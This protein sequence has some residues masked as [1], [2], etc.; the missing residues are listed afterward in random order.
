M[1]RYRDD[2][3][4]EAATNRVMML[5]AVLLFA[6]V[7]VFPLYRLIEPL[8][9]DDAR[10]GQLQ[11]LAQAGE[12]SWSV[13]CASCHGVS[14]DGAIGP[15]LNSMQ[16][17]QAASDDQIGSLIGVGVPGSQMNPYSQDHGGPLTSEQIKSL[18]VFI[19]S[20]EEDAP[21]RPDWRAMLGG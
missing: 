2:I 17:L 5:G 15:A 1:A 9:R 13:N 12:Q 16:F 14:G 20:W 3:E 19:R 11:A 7:A 8:N 10:E 4:L 21:D 18:V 6:M